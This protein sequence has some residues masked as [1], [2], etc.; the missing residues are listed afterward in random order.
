MEEARTETA[1]IE[2]QK[3]VTM[4]GVAAVDSF[5]PQQIN[6]TLDSGRAVITGE[7]LKIVNFS[8]SAGN[9]SAVGKV[10]GIRFSGKKE[11]L[12]KRLFG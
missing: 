6:I 11:K 4:T 1:L 9:F 5:T 3:K 10:T 8:K 12:S 7:G 2:Q